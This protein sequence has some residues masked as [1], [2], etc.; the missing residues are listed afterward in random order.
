MREQTSLREKTPQYALP[1]FKMKHL[2]VDMKNEDKK[3]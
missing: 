1:R 2:E 3:Y